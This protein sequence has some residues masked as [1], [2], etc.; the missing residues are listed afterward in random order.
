M[1]NLILFSL[2]LFA[3]GSSS[4]A[5]NL[6]KCIE[7]I[8]KK[9]NITTTKFERVIQLSGN[10]TVYEFSIKSIPN[11]IHCDRGFVYYDGN[12]NMIAFFTNARGPSGFVADGY[13][14]SEFG[15]FN[16]NIRMRYGEKQEPVAPCITKIIANAD[17]LKKAGVEKIVQVRIKQKILYGFEH[18]VDPKLAN[19]KDCSK[20]ITY[21]NE[22]CKPEVTFIVGGIAGVK[23]D[24]GYTVSDFSNKRTLKI[25]WNAN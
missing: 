4:Q 23:G 15:Q 3:I 18:K 17:S 24:N 14:A 13:N 25:L 7:K 11:C 21:Y 1:K 12:C 2:L 10:R 6:P 9:D 5:Q 19:C 22:D 16:K 20:S 8:N